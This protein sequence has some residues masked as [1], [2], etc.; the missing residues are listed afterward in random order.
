[1]FDAVVGQDIGGPQGLEDRRIQHRR[2]QYRLAKLA[3]AAHA[4]RITL[5]QRLR[6]LA[7]KAHTIGVNAARPQQHDAIPGMQLRAQ[8]EVRTRGDNAHTGGGQINAAGRNYARQGR[9][10]TTAPGHF[11]DIAGGLPAAHQVFHARHVG[12]PVTA[13]RCPIGVD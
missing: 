1:M 9:R 6:K 4:G 7:G 2:I 12:E 10:L 13:T 11:A 3:T 5:R 8:R